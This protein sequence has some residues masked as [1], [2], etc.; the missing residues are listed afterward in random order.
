MLGVLALAGLDLGLEQFMVV[1]I[2]PA[3][4]KTYDA[5]L[6]TAAWL[7]TGFLLAAAA[8]V[9]LFSRLG[10]LHGK[11]R[12]LLI[13]LGTFA[14]GSLVCALAGSIEMLIAGRVVQGA[15]AALGPLAIGL[16]RDHARPERVATW[17]GLLIAG[18]GAGIAVGLLLGGVLVDAF[19][20]SAVFW[21]LFGLAVLLIAAVAYAVPESPRRDTGRVDWIGALL[22]SSALVAA[23]LA[24]S[25]GNAWGWAS[26][27]VI[28]VLA[29]AA[30]LLGA[31]AAY[32]RYVEAPVLDVRLLRQRSVWS[33]NLVA[34]TLGFVLIVAGLVI[35]QLGA[36]PRSSGYGL[37]LTTTEIG[38]LLLPSGLA[39]IAGGWA[40]G[41]LVSRVGAR[42][43]VAVG[44]A[45]AAAAYV[46]LIVFHES[47]AWVAV[48]NAMLGIGVS[49]G[50]TAAM[51][52]A[53]HSVGHARTA[54]FAATIALSRTTGG[55]LGGQIA[56][57]VIIG[58]GLAAQG[59]PAQEGFTGSFVLGAAAAGV[60]LVATVTM[61]R[62]MSDPSARLGQA[63]Q[64]RAAS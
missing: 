16:A 3:V 38:F 61:P 44:T 6:G 53:V 37:G 12:M 57:A 35:P 43:L 10:D 2:V 33:A 27:R 36:L 60:A 56:A 1:P 55:A 62:R 40:S 29:I 31:F 21:F 23:L 32:E 7:L 54:V 13:A 8:T 42:S 47:I 17:I 28:A 34:F 49:V 15:G 58:A 46:V 59:L 64:A 50:F 18:A 48:A 11:R 24:I 20:V 5:P 63:E 22:L 39:I 51:N 45:F 14:T 30:A 25:E 19:A 26:G 52:L 41:A 9:P 4:Q